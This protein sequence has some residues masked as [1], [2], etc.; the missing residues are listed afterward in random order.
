[1]G[2]HRRKGVGSVAEVSA[3]AFVERSW[4]TTGPGSVRG[5]A[6]V[7]APAFVERERQRELTEGYCQLKP[8]PARL[9]G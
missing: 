8:G 5:V 1:M 7:S 2:Q 3:P 9:R 4:Q 6:G